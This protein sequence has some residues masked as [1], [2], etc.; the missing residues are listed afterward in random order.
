MNNGGTLRVEKPLLDPRRPFYI[1]EVTLSRPV[2]APMSTV[3][4]SLHGA[5]VYSSELLTASPLYEFFPVLLASTITVIETEGTSFEAG[6]LTPFH[7]KRSV[8]ISR[9]Q[10]YLQRNRS[11]KRG[12]SF[13]VLPRPVSF[14]P[15]A[16]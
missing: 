2:D 1:P 5:F 7:I 8:N 4:G 15:V 9:K 10:I 11:A 6:P 16:P 13:A 12:L 14:P 3:V